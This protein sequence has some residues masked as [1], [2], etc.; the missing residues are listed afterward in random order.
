MQQGPGLASWYAAWLLKRP[1][2]ERL[3]EREAV[4]TYDIGDRGL[5]TAE[6]SPLLLLNPEIRM[7][8]HAFSGSTSVDK[9]RAHNS[10]SVV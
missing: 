3:L 6:V 9:T 1:S 7:K 4:R 5:Q 10:E 2:S 8:S